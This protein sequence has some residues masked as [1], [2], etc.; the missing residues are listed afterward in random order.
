M[1]PFDDEFRS[2]NYAAEWVEATCYVSN[3]E[4]SMSI[5]RFS[6]KEEDDSN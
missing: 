2:Y 4:S 1:K 6:C 5:P 3:V